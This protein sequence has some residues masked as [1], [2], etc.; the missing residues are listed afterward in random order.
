MGHGRVR[1]DALP[2]LFARWALRVHDIPQ[3]N[4]RCLYLLRD[5]DNNFHQS[6]IG[7]AGFSAEAW[8]DLADVVAVERD[9]CVNRTREESRS[10]RT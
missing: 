5:I 2:M 4:H 10:D 6:W 3:S 1:H 8:K 9:V 7:L